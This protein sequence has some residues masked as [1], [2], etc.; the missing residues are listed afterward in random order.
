M[1]PRSHA[2]LALLTHAANAGIRSGRLDPRNLNSDPIEPRRS[3]LFD[4]PLGSIP[5]RVA[6]GGWRFDEIRIAV[7]AWPTSDVDQWIEACRANEL[8]GQVT[9]IGYLTRG[10]EGRLRLGN[11]F[12]PMIYIRRDRREAMQ[13][14]PVPTDAA[15]PLQLYPRYL[16]NAAAA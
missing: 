2:S 12:D 8:A 4:A 6:V 15:D 1:S 9:A 5:M 10:A 16:S 13:A 3:V 11:P 14:L 7:A